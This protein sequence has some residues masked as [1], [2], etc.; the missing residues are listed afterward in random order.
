M[1]SRC[2]KCSFPDS[3]VLEPAGCPGFGQGKKRGSRLLRT[4][5][6]LKKLPRFASQTTLAREVDMRQLMQGRAEPCRGCVEAMALRQSPRPSLLGLT[7]R[8]GQSTVHRGMRERASQFCHSSLEQPGRGERR[9]LSL[10]RGYRSR[11]RQRSG[12]V[13]PLC[14]EDAG[15]VKTHARPDGVPLRLRSAGAVLG[16]GSNLT[17]MRS[18]SIAIAGGGFLA[19][20]T[21]SLSPSR[22]R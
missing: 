2:L 21:V 19:Q 12:C 1:D 15:A 4:E 17:C 9:L 10:L 6:M 11:R 14:F 18:I 8:G 16:D 20:T 22:T 13:L 3:E 5:D 7:L